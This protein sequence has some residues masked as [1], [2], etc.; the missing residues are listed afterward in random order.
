MTERTCSID[1]CDG[2][3][4]AAKGWCW[5]HYRRWLRHGDPEHPPQPRT[6]API[7]DRLQRHIQQTEAGCWEWTGSRTNNY[8]RIQVDGA[9]RFSHRVMYELAVGPIP[10]G[11]HLDH[12]CRNPPC[13]NPQHLEAVTP[14]ENTRRGEGHG[15]E[16]HC[17][18]GH[19]YDEAN[20]YRYRDRRY[21]RVCKRLNFLAFHER[22]RNA[23]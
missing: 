5:K 16:T 17:P 21:C 9:L 10:D 1:G 12:L 13:C 22:K 4:I 7:M 18:R 2:T 14:L 23:A 19:P 8:G 3:N 6:P 11:F 20:T 15:S